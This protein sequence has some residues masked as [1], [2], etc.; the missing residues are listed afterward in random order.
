[1]FAMP[2]KDTSASMRCIG[3][4]DQYQ[5]YSLD[6]KNQPLLQLWLADGR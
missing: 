5:F 3:N 4:E 2:H 1:M 6:P